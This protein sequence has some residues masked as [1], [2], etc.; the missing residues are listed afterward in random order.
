MSSDWPQ[1]AT[2]HLKQ[3]GNFRPT[4]LEKSR[5]V[6][7]LK[8]QQKRPGMSEAHLVLVRA[9]PCIVCGT[10]KDIH[11][12]HLKSGPARDERSLGAKATDQWTVPLC[13][14]HHLADVELVGSKRELEWF[15]SKSIMDP[16]SLAQGLWTATR[17]G[18]AAMKKVWDAHWD[19]AQLEA[20]RRLRAALAMRPAARIAQ[21]RR[22]MKRWRRFRGVRY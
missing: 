17:R 10:R 14:I 1:D 18:L 13:A 3:Y 11:A 20:G 4:A 7:P 21:R 6:K 5:R 16:Y 15:E 9:L 12:H 2:A 8:W 22:F 19:A